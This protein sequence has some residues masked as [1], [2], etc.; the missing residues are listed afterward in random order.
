LGLSISAL[1]AEWVVVLPLGW[2]LGYYSLHASS[3]HS[4]TELSTPPSFPDIPA[5]IAALVL[6]L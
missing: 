2:P 4:I 3:G 5:L 6:F 1:V